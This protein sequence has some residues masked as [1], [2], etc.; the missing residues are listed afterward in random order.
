[1][2]TSRKRSYST[3]G[4]QAKASRIVGGKVLTYI[5]RAPVAGSFRSRMPTGRELNFQDIDL[6]GQ[7]FSTTG[8]LLLLNG[9][10]QGT[11]ASTRIGR[12]VTVKS[13]QWAFDAATSSST[14]WT[15]NRYMIVQDTQANGA[16]ATFADIYA[17]AQPSTLRNMSN[18]PRFKVLYDSKSFIMIGDNAGV[19]SSAYDVDSLATAHQG[20]IKCTVPVQ[21]NSGNSGTVAD[22]QTNALYFVMIGNG[23]TSVTDV[24]IAAGTARI[25]FSD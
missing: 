16:G 15:A 13:V 24:N 10:S 9:L 21:Y 3:V 8:V 19:G 20:Y 4:G 12:R 23:T 5:P 1:M 18:M 2:S 6:S 17:T 7:S 22:I 14:T 25:R 11:T